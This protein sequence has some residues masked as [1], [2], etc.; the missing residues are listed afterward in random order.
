MAS[1]QPGPHGLVTATVLTSAPP[2]AGDTTASATL[3]RPTP[4]VASSASAGGKSR[5]VVYWHVNSSTL[6]PVNSPTLPAAAG[7]IVA[8]SF[9]LFTIPIPRLSSMEC[10]DGTSLL[11][12]IVKECIFCAAVWL[13]ASHSYACGYG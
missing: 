12:G 9:A 5:F 10:M 4:T 1:S 11:R 8:Y 2:T 6:A 13:G 3:T 7:P